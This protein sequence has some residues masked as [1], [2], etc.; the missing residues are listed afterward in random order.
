MKTLDEVTIKRIKNNYPQNWID[1]MMDQGK[2]DKILSFIDRNKEIVLTY[3]QVFFSP[4]G[5]DIYELNGERR[6]FC[7]KNSVFPTAP[8]TDK[9][10]AGDWQQWLQKAKKIKEIR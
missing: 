2:I 1:A 5:F 6:I 8:L 9:D 3:E 10:A 4:N 7:V